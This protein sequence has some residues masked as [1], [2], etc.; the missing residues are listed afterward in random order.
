MAP[1][2]GWHLHI[3]SPLGPTPESPSWNPSRTPVE[4][5]RITVS[6]PTAKAVT[7]L[8]RSK[9][10]L[11]NTTVK[12]CFRGRLVL[13][14]HTGPAA[15]HASTCA[16]PEVRLMMEQDSCHLALPLCHAGATP[17]DRAG[18]CVRRRP[19]SRLGSVWSRP[20]WSQLDPTPHP[21]PVNSESRA[22]SQPLSGNII[23]LL[24]WGVVR[25]VHNRLQKDAVSVH[26]HASLCPEH[27][28][29]SLY[30]RLRSASPLGRC[31]SPVECLAV[32][33]SDRLH[34]WAF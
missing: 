15:V 28:A 29:L 11:L 30:F 13:H 12:S 17:W 26:F 20:S 8:G 21:L 22:P 4:N 2:S 24:R 16:G 9:T 18:C 10:F 33:P 34:C 27:P 31:S 25:N 14:W 1:A 32:A 23:F 7:S 5:Q 6:P 19:G 3:H